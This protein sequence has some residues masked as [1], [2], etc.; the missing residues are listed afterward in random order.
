MDEQSPENYMRRALEL[1]RRAEGQ[2]RPNPAVGAVIVREGRIVGEGFHPAAGA[3]HAEIFALDQAGELA[4]GATLYVTLEPCCHTGRTG[5]CSTAVIVAGIAKVVAGTRDPNPK[6]A[7][8]GFEQLRSA[9]I[10]VESGLLADEC[11]RLIAPFAKHVT[12]GL[13]LV[14]LKAAATLDGQLATRTGESQWITGPQSRE[15]GHR[16]RH[17]HDAILVGSGTILADNPRLTTRLPEGGGKDPLRIVLD[18]RLRTPPDAALLDR[19]SAAG[20][21][22]V[23]TASAPLAAEQQLLGA[24]AEILRMAGP[25]T[26][27]NLPAL[28]RLLGDRGLQSLLLEGGGRLNHAAWHAGI[29]DRVAYFVAPTFLGGRG[30]PVF[31]GD[32]V[33]RLA[34]AVRLHEVRMECLGADL[35]IEGEVNRCSPD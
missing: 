26:T 17:V 13:P 29:V 9:G 10:T 32:G 14:T 4:R 34:D 16:L 30:L 20:V 25:G 28:M 19:A 5:P 33:G 6:V 18:S 3:A 11:R 7:G 8:G 24:G 22:I 21:L 15:R 1:A 31:A 23:T 27:I 2:T 12:T 35:L